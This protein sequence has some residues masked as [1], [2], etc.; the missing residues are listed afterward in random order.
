MR[1]IYTQVLV[2]QNIEEFPRQRLLQIQ[3]CH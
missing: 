1:Q 2:V 3:P